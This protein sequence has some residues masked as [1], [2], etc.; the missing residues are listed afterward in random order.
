MAAPAFVPGDLLVSVPHLPD[1]N[2]RRTVVL[3]LHHDDD[4]AFGVVLN[5]PLEVEVGSVLP[6]WDSAVSAPGVLFQGG[7]VGLDAALGLVAL[8]PR[9]EMPPSVTRV[10]GVFGLVDLDSPPP[11]GD[12][13]VVGLRI[14]AG[15][16]GW[17]GG[18]LEG[19]VAAGDWFV[20][21]A[22]PGDL[23]TPDPTR[24]WR[25]VLRRQGGTLA[26]A[27]TFPED[28]RLN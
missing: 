14:F 1:P 24:L 16:S 12:D 8:R 19:E 11:D 2:F 22:L 26:M 4:G 27:S 25:T 13:V 5:R 15:H 18:Q 9:A 23:W 10:A 17:A 3:L 6:G 20:V 21:P 7:P 28:P